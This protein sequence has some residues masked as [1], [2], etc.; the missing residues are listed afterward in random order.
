MSE[1]AVGKK[2]GRP[3]SEHTKTRVISI[4]LSEQDAERLAYIQEKLGETPSES[5]REGLRM[6]YNIAMFAD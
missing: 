2:R 3:K 1:K 6:R 4:R 5:V